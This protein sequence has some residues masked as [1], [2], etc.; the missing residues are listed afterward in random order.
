MGKVP[1]GYPDEDQFYDAL[2]DFMNDDGPLPIPCSGEDC[3][4]RMM[5]Y[6]TTWGTYKCP[7]CGQ[8]VCEC[9]VEEYL[10]NMVNDN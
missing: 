5:D 10:E 6:D 8:E 3:G 1:E 7:L 4:G 9:D 2:D